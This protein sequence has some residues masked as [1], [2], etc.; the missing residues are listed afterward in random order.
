MSGA[1]DPMAIPL[2]NLE[3]QFVDFG[4]ACKS[5]SSPLVSGEEGLR[6]LEVVTA[7]YRSCR[8][9]RRVQIG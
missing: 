1:S 2:E 3:R 6:A 9:E 8:E 5:G 4:N 7:V